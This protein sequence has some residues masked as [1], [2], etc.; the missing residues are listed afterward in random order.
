MSGCDRL[1]TLAL[2]GTVS[3]MLNYRSTNFLWLTAGIALTLSV[4]AWLLLGETPVAWALIVIAFAVGV[5]ASTSQAAAQIGALYFDQDSDEVE[6]RAYSPRGAFFRC[7]YLGCFGAAAAL[8]GR[9]GYNLL[10]DN[11]RAVAFILGPILLYYLWAGA[12]YVNSISHLA[13]R[14]SWQRQKLRG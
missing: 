6:R 9:G 4:G 7:C 3:I 10:P 13:R 11:F 1:R 5:E 2:R 8:L 14:E 12:S